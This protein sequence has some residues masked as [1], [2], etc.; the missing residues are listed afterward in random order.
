M[1]TA[2]DTGFITE[3]CKEINRC[4]TLLAMAGTGL[5]LTERWQ[6]IKMFMFLRA[7]KTEKTVNGFAMI[8]RVRW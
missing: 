6:S 7:T 2:E 1:K 5:T 3:Q 4:M 8:K